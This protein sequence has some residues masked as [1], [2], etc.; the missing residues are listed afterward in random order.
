MSIPVYIG[1]GGNLDNPMQTIPLALHDI[2]QEADVRVLKCSSLYRSKP[3]GPQ[4][5]ADFCNAVGQIITTLSALALLDFLQAIEQKYGRVRTGIRWG[6]RTLDL[7]I[8]L[9][10]DDVISEPRLSVPHPQMLNRSFVL[11]PL[12]EIAPDLVIPQYG[13]IKQA[14]AK[15]ADDDLQLL[16]PINIWA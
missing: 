13:A 4:N 1:L 5:Q 9:Y 14:L 15:V 2:N 8:L 16:Q 6:A 12:A 3:Q 11:Y 7:D 10:A